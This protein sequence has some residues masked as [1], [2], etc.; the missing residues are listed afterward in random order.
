MS[1]GTPEQVLKSMVD[2]IST[3]NLDALMP[4]YEPAAA[5]R[6]SLEASVTA[7]RV[8]VNPWLLSLRGLRKWCQ[9]WFHFNEMGRKALSACMRLSR[10]TTPGN[11]VYLVLYCVTNACG[12]GKASRDHS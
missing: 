10:R 2:G 5:L 6:V 8:S 9:E 3:G 4:L 1:T 12:H 7:Y 11:R